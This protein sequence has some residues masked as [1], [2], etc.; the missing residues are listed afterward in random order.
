VQDCAESIMLE[1]AKPL[2]FYDDKHWGKY[3]TITSNTFGKGSLTYIGTVLN[4]ELMESVLHKA[5]L[6]AGINTPAQ[7]LAFLLIV[8]SGVNDYG[9]R[10]YYIFNYS[11]GIVSPNYPYNNGVES[12]DNQQIKANEQLKIEPWGVKIIEEK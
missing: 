5:V 1:T 10:I 3:P 12:L 7:K 8:R 6:N 2:A 11:D 4:A 9:K